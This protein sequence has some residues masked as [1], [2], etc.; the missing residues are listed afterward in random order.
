MS[1]GGD[2]DLASLDPVNRVKAFL[3]RLIPPPP[4]EPPDLTPQRAL[5]VL[6]EKMGEEL[7]KTRD[8]GDNNGRQSLQADVDAAKTQLNESKPN[9]A[10][11]NQYSTELKAASGRLAANLR[12]SAVVAKHIIAAQAFKK[13]IDNNDKLQFKNDAANALRNALID[14]DP[15]PHSTQIRGVQ[16]AEEVSAILLLHAFLMYFF[17]IRGVRSPGRDWDA[18]KPKSA[19][20]VSRMFMSLLDIPA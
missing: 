20:H 19:Q 2:G 8:T 17:D 18:V 7:K 14:V 3:E 13:S 9:T 4:L 11:Y 5:L 10:A 15:V 1:A 16:P 6:L 12:N